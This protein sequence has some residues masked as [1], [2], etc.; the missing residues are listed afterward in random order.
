MDHLA[1]ELIL[2]ILELSV[3]VYDL[4]HYCEPQ[5]EYP[6]LR[7]TALVCKAWV[8]PSQV[9]LWRYVVLRDLASAQRW[10]ESPI[11]G[12][13]TTWRLFIGGD[14]GGDREIKDDVVQLVL[15]KTV[16]LRM[17]NLG[18]QIQNNQGRRCVRYSPPHLGPI[19]PSYL[20]LP[21]LKDLTALIASRCTISEFEAGEF[22]FAFRLRYFQTMHTQIH[23]S[24][25]E[26]LLR[27]SATTL[28]GLAL[29]QHWRSSP[30]VEIPSVFIP[31][32][33]ASCTSLKR[34]KLSDDMHECVAPMFHAVP[35]SLQDLTIVGKKADIDWIAPLL[36][37]PSLQRLERLHLEHEAFQNA[38]KR[39]KELV[40][41]LRAHNTTLVEIPTGD[42]MPYPDF[43][44]WRRW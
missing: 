34:L 17:L 38:H 22:D 14:L 31:S 24:V 37:L 19:S 40:E 42:S 10:T 1:P 9:L 43:S 2:Q 3:G 18:P 15:G 23:A 33:L 12:Q 13:Y 21:N 27:K 6:H 20:A 4:H 11:N 44:I 8:A 25:I 28:E 32:A 30:T 39:R 7:N 29:E 35:T 36:G 41:L 26:E 5:Q 16:G